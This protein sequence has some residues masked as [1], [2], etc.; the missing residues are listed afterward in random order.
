MNI[1]TSLRECPE[2]LDD[3][4]GLNRRN[5]K[6]PQSQPQ[7]T[8][9]PSFRARGQLRSFVRLSQDRS[10][11]GGKDLTGRGELDLALGT[12]KKPGTEF[13]F[14]SSHLLAERGLA[15]VEPLGGAAEVEGIGDGQEVTEMAKFHKRVLR[16]SL[17]NISQKSGFGTKNIFYRIRR[18]S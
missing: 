14:E 13:R 2:A 7:V 8:E 12:V 4:S 10:G 18:L 5:W 16:R 3:Q 1:R 15:Q 9:F 11:L 17:C 6:L